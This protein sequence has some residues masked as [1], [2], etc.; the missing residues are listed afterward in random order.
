MVKLYIKFQNIKLNTKKC[1][2]NGKVNYKFLHYQP[3][4]Y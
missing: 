3:Y 4:I 2:N 1:P